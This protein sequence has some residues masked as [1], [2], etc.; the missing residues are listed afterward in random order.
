MAIALEFINFI[1]PIHII[2]NKY[3]GGWEACLR[4]HEPLI[5]GRVYY[6]D[7][8]FRDGAM[9]PWD[10]GALVDEWVQRGLEATREIDGERHSWDCCIVSVPFGPDL[11]CDWIKI[12][13]DGFSAYLKGTKPGDVMGLKGTKPRDVVG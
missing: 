6:D 11:P 1:V 4:D 3:P 8:L 5:G 2:K 9:S 10:A 7:H 13:D 12:T